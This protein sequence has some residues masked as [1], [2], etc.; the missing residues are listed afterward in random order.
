M[1]N[2]YQ[3][4]PGPIEN[5]EHFPPPVAIDC[6]KVDKVYEECKF[7]DVNEL[8][9]T[10]DDIDQLTDVECIS[11]EVIEKKCEIVYDDKVRLWIKYEVTYEVNGE[12]RSH[13]E[14]FEKIVVLAR[15][16]E[17]G[18]EPQCE[19]FL[20]CLDAFVLKNNTIKLCIGK[21]LLFKLIAHVQLLVP[22]YGFCPEPKE[23][24]VA[25]ECPE[26][27]PIWPPYPEQS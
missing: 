9:I 20:E 19:V 15:A 13:V 26:F 7:T 4:Y 6:I 23:C 24:Q 21:L 1:P 18:L 2:N 14:T 3:M 16:G 5:P 12:T 27:D 10:L 8:D 22:V 17:D 25:G 11:V